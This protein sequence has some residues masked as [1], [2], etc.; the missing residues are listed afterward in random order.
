MTIQGSCCLLPTKTMKGCLVDT[1]N[2]LTD[3]T[4]ECA[5]CEVGYFLEDGL[6]Y[7]LPCSLPNCAYCE[8]SS[9]CLV[10]QT[11]YNLVDS[12]C[13]AYTQPTGCPDLCVACGE[14]GICT[15]CLNGYTIFEGQCVCP[16]QNCLQCMGDLFCIKCA[17]PFVPEPFNNGGCVLKPVPNTLCAIPNCHQCSTVNV[18]SFCT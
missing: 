8:G 1:L 15:Q 13:V 7:Q 4:Y 16:F 10:C 2:L 3:C 11:G 18:C 5:Q 17:D 14:D 9:A 12:T 6:C